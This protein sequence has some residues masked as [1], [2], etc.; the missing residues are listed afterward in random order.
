MP[1]PCG[2]LPR[3]RKIRECSFRRNAVCRQGLTTAFRRQKEHSMTH[4]HTFPPLSNPGLEVAGLAGD[5]A[6]LV[7]SLV[8][9]SLI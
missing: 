8:L 7:D 6:A 9:R 3:V 2:V 4:A 5:E 1:E